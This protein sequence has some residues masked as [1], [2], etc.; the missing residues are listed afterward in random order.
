MT[1]IIVTPIDM[2][3]PGS[4]KARKQ[5]LQTYAALQE[6]QGSSDIRKLAEAF[7]A[8][9]ALILKHAETDDGTTIGEALEQASA[10]DFDA[11]L[12]A[13]ISGETVPN[14]TASD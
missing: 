1:K 9:E 2:S 7:D 12:G 11:L 8:I 13:I 4:Y 10:V 6:A 14:P 3:A 5:L